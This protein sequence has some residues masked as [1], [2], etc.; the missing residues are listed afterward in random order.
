[1]GWNESPNDLAGD[2]AG[3]I[4]CVLWAPT[5]AASNRSSPGSGWHSPGRN[6][7]LAE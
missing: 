4:G 7:V 5:R 1:M 6:F 2:P 3:A